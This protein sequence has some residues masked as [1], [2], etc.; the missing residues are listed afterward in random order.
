MLVDFHEMLRRLI[1]VQSR[2]CFTKYVVDIASTISSTT[3]SAQPAQ[4]WKAIKK[5]L[6][7]SKSSSHS[8]D[9][10]IPLLISNDG[11][12]AETN[13]QKAKVFFSTSQTLSILL[14]AMIMASSENIILASPRLSLR[15]TSIV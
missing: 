11:V 14:F 2:N 3:L 1:K 6:A 13:A 4:A 5:L 9:K 15:S 12:P 7:L 10:S 8:A